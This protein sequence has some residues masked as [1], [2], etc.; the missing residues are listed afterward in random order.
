MNKSEYIELAGIGATAGIL[1]VAHDALPENMDAGA[2]IA[3]AILPALIQMLVRD[4]WLMSCPANTDKTPRSMRC[5]CL[6]SCVAYLVLAAAVLM[7][8]FGR[9][10]VLHPTAAAWIGA[11]TFAQTLTFLMKDWVVDLK[12]LRLRRDPDHINLIF[13]W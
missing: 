3:L 8:L 11:V 12:T 13:K 2:F 4:L 1:T 5:M 7:I 6:E 9:G 10:K